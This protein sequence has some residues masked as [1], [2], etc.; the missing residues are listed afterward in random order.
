MKKYITWLHA[1]DSKCWGEGT[2]TNP[3]VATGSLILAAILGVIAALWTAKSTM[4]SGEGFNTL[5]LAFALIFLTAINVGE[6]IYACAKWWQMLLRSLA[7]IVAIPLVC[8]ISYAGSIV[9]LVVIAL[10]IAILFGSALLSGMGNSSG[11]SKK[12][13]LSDGTEVKES[14]GI[15]G[16]KYYHGS[17]GRDYTKNSDDSFTRE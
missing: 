9:A 17:D 6:S 16:E 4:N 1:F 7:L 11:G 2:T 12:W 5:H 3:Y 14:S 13:R 8:A 10:A 15:M